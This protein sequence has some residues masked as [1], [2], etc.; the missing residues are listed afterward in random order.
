MIGRRCKCSNVF[1]RPVL[2]ARTLSQR[3]DTL[4]RSRKEVLSS[5][6][7]SFLSSKICGGYS[8][9]VPPLPIPN[10]EVKP[11][12]ADG[13]ALSGV[14]VGSCRFSTR[15][16]DTGCPGFLFVLSSIIQNA[17]Y[18]GAIHQNSFFQNAILVRLRLFLR[19][20]CIVFLF[21]LF[22]YLFFV[23]Q[24][25]CLSF[26]ILFAMLLLSS[27]QFHFALYF[28]IYSVCT[29]SLCPNLFSLSRYYSYTF[30]CHLF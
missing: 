23:V 8:G 7:W 24:K 5:L 3:K 25:C 30:F 6:P 16:S 19:L 11:V 12:I 10:R 29:M 27:G 28:I 20:L 21:C 1:S 15:T 17:I 14:R 26:S 2:I 4:K 13:S 18:R 22:S 9:G